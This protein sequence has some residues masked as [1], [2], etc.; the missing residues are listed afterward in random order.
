MVL[1]G[2][3]HSSESS[4]DL[5]RRGP[6][7]VEGLQLSV[8]LVHSLHRNGGPDLTNLASCHFASLHLLQVDCVLDQMS[9][10]IFNHSLLA[11][12]NFRVHERK[13]VS[14]YAQVSRE[15]HSTLHS[16]PALQLLNGLAHKEVM[17]KG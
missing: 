9:Q 17:P 10:L 5:D 1:A 7:V 13:A 4:L 12:R 15:G 14:Y 16:H 3:A 11:L 8:A 6:L 2:L